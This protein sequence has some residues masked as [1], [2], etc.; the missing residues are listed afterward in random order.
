[1][2]TTTRNKGLNIA[3]WIVQVMLAGMFA[4][5]GIMKI[6]TPIEELA[7]TLKWASDLPLLVRFIGASE[8]AAALGL[9]LP[10]LLRIKPILTPVAATGLIVI[11]MLAAVFHITR[12]E[13]PAIGFNALLGALA[14]FI[15]W[16]RFKKAPILA[17][18]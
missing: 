13:Y 8:L 17:K 5:A 7:T 4:M 1:M 18:A 15:T 9:V 6:S 11:M 10:A 16:G 14:F 3:L 2:S 12:A